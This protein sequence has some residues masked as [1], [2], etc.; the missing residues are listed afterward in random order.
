MR[1]LSVGRVGAAVSAA[2]SNLTPLIA[3]LLAI[4]LLGE[5][6]TP[7]VLVGTVVIV[8]GTVLLSTSGARLGFR[9]WQIVFP[10]VSATCFGIVAVMRKVALGGMGPVLGA[11]VNFTSAFVAFTAVMLASRHRGI[12][13]CRGRTLVHFIAAGIAENTGV[14]LVITALSAGSV[15]VVLPLASSVPIFVLVL[16]AIFLRDIEV[17][18]RRVVVGT[19]MIVAGVYLITALGR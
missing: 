3:T 18:T 15:S 10:L 6:V 4:T 8:A 19:L 16:S 11:A 2:V 12:Y 17:L 5:R 9:P 13:G 7:T 14:L 1:F